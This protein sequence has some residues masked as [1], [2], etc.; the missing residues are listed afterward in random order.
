MSFVSTYFPQCHVTALLESL[1]GK[2]E[3]YLI[4]YAPD[5]P[6]FEPMS[7][8]AILPVLLTDNS[9]VT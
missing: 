3:N 7:T 8:V 4:E 5:G 2:Q 6:I 9:L 1:L